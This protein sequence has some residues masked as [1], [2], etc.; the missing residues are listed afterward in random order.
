MSWHLGPLCAFDSET[1]GVD[2]ENDRIVSAAAIRMHEGR[3]NPSTWL[4]DA[5]GL[6]IPAETTAI[7]GISTEHARA[8]GKPA[9]QVVAEIVT[10]LAGAVEEGLP[11]VGHNVAFDLSL[12]DREARRHLGQDLYTALGGQPY[13]IDTMVLDRLVAPSRRRVS[14]DQGPYQLRT[15]AE[16]YGLGWSEEAAHGA[17][18]DALMAGR[19]A[20]H[21]GHIAHLAP[22]D[23]PQWV[24]RLH[25]GRFDKLRDLSLTELHER[26]ILWARLDAEGY[27]KWLRDP[28]KSKEK[29]DANAV[30]D[31]TWPLRPLPT[32][33]VATEGAEV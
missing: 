25:P 7:H 5:D 32:P 8:H 14:E 15:T 12:L 33:A 19:I 21:Q 10:V 30:I 31:G 3:L 11:I 17:E 26:Q 24:R 1:T 22:R 16:T 28:A 20:W 6:D 2:V 4:S 9:K 27:Q 13:V 23:R 29:H 18:Y